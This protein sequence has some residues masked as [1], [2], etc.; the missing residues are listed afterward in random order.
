[1]YTQACFTYTKWHGRHTISPLKRHDWCIGASYC[2]STILSFERCFLIQKLYQEIGDICWHSKLA[3]FRFSGQSGQ[4]GQTSHINRSDRSIKVCQIVN[5]TA[6]LRRSR[7]DD[8]NAYMEHPIWSPNEK[9]MPSGRPAPRSNR[10][11][12]SSGGQT[13]LET[14]QTS[15]KRPIRVRRYILIWDLLEFQ[16][17]MGTDL[18]T[19]Y[20]YEGPRPIEGNL[21]RFTHLSFTFF[22]KP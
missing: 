15:P 7:W 11:D 14:S 18:P 22:S 13:S 9:V 4:T 8:Q 17:L 3:W 12:R 5:W 1:M 21:N 16:L 6:P 2:F 20:I 10:P 19:L